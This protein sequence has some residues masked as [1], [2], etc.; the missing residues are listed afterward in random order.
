M[1]IKDRT[2]EF[3]SAVQAFS[4]FTMPLHR[5]DAISKSEFMAAASEIAKQ[6]YS[7]GA[8]LESLA[9]RIQSLID[10]RQE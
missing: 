5:S 2:G 3:M 6:V 1:T 10:S 7:V 8:K 4:T 9:K